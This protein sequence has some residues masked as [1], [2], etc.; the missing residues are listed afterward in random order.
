MVTGPPLAAGAQGGRRPQTGSAHSGDCAGSGSGGWPR[1]QAPS[2]IAEGFCAAPIA[3]GVF[4]KQQERVSRRV[5]GQE[6][7]GG[8]HS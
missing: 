5:T 8:R 3:S 6:E 2:P 4:S 7:T 1:L